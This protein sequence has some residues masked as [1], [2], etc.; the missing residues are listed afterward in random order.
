MQSLWQDLRYG[1]RMLARSPGLAA[2]SVL[3]LALG[4]GLNSVMF[5]FVDQMGLQRLPVRDPSRI[6]SISPAENSRGFAYADRE[7]FADQCR[8]FSEVVVMSDEAAVTDYL[9]LPRRVLANVVSRNYFRFLGLRPTAGRFFG[10]EDNPQVR[11]EA[12]V[13]LSYR[14]WMRD[15]GGNPA[16]VG[17]PIQ[18]SGMTMTVVGVAPKGF[19]GTR[20]YAPEDCW[21]PVETWHAGNPRWLTL[22]TISLCTL[23]ARLNPDVSLESAQAE[24]A[25]LA[26]RLTQTYRKGQRAFPVKVSSIAPARDVRLYLQAAGAMVL[27]ALVMAIAC[28]NVSGL[29]I[30][31]GATRAKETAVRAALGGAR[32]RLMR[33]MLAENLLLSVAGGALGLLLATW[34]IRLL[35]ALL[36]SSMMSPLPELYVDLRLVGFAAGLSLVATLLFGLLP[37]WRASR[38][39]LTSLLKGD[40]GFNPSGGRCRGRNLLVIAQL[41]VSLV[42]LIVSGLFVGSLRHQ[43][44]VGPGFH[45]RDLLLVEVSPLQYGVPMDRVPSYLREVQERVATLTGVKRFGIVTSLPTHYRSAGHREATALSSHADDPIRTQRVAWNRVSGDVLALLGT[46]IVRGRNLDLTDDRSAE[47]VALINRSGARCFWPNED[48][49]GRWIRLGQADENRCR[50]VGIVEDG[51]Y[52]CEDEQPKPYVFVP[53]QQW[54]AAE[55]TLLVDASPGPQAVIDPVRE[56]LRRINDRVRPVSV[57]TLHAHLR[58]SHFMF[59]RRL[60]AQVFGAFGLLGLVLAIVGLYAVIAHAV[61]QRTHEIGIRMAVGANRKTIVRM[62]LRWGLTLALLGVAVG[63]PIAVAAAQ[64]FRSSLF[65]FRATDPVTFAGVVLLLMAVSLLASYLPARRAA[66]VDPM[67]ALRYE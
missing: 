62:V 52:C 55:A 27:P 1:V 20:R 41:A 4:I 47:R 50:V 48:P 11:A 64:L 2:V 21:I 14:L 23:L 63:L 32:W 13:V 16:I 60:L 25:V 18:L 61:G 26:Q 17:T 35:P 15:F 37:A 46:R 53:L 22:R 33:H 56:E 29:L 44:K 12:V 5:S 51:A 24:A 3:S 59:G 40:S 66:R 28:A 31:R 49:V 30:A 39:E 38:T 8:S 36:P 67:E 19:S 58:S 65:G 43:L 9:E 10:E 6:V 54:G 42:L 34:T 45:M 7:D 57:Q